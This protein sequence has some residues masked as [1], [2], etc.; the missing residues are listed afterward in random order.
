MPLKRQLY[1]ALHVWRGSSEL[2]IRQAYKRRALETHPDKG[3]FVGL[4]RLESCARRL[5]R[6]LFEG[7]GSLYGALRPF[8]AAEIR[9]PAAAAQGSRRRGAD[10]EAE[11]A[12]GLEDG[13]WLRDA[14]RPRAVRHEMFI[15]NRPRIVEN[16]GKRLEIH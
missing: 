7:R 13:P 3:L 8:G 15:K 10:A 11:A 16:D 2:E 12:Q 5:P 14:T 1:A 4:A 9:R 6:G